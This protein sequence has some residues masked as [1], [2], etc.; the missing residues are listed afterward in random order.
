MGNKP[1]KLD[2]VEE[3]VRARLQA[4]LGLDVVQV[5]DGGGHSVHDLAI[6]YPDREPAPV[7]VTA[8]VDQA[9]LEAHASNG[10]E[11]WP[12]SLVCSWTLSSDGRPPNFRLL[13][14]EAEGL[15]VV[16]ETYGLNGF[17]P[18]TTISYQVRAAAGGEEDLTVWRALQRLD[19]LHVQHGHAWS[20]TTG[21][22]T[23][24][25]TLSRGGTWGGAADAV[26]SWVTEF[27]ND[28][29]RADNIRKL[30]RGGEEAHLAIHVELSGAGYAVWQALL[31]ED[32]HGLLPGTD[33]RVPSTVTDIWLSTSFARA[34]VL[35]WTTRSGWTRNRSSSQQ[36]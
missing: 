36:C 26:S 34:D 20:R 24:C 22:Q 27:V 14:R 21:P 31:D 19:Q 1:R 30:D 16:L 28:P 12:T 2:P 29:V 7:E 10:M 35:H 32:R 15:L 23:I 6:Q 11:P 4:I 17:G 3:A 5:D 13:R 9:E 33:P 18:G 25:P 8:A